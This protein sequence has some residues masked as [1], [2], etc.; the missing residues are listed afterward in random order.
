MVLPG[1]PYLFLSFGAVYRDFV[2]PTLVAS[3]LECG[4]EER[5]HDVLSF[6]VADETGG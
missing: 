6:L 5:V 4:E 3:S 1:K 2:Y